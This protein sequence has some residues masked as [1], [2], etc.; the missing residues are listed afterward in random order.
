LDLGAPVSG[1]GLGGSSRDRIAEAVESGVDLLESDVLPTSEDALDAVV[2]ENPP[3][4]TETSAVDLAMSS[5]VESGRSRS[6]EE[7]IDL[8]APPPVS[9]EDREIT[10]G[11][12][13]ESDAIDLG[14]MFGG[15]SASSAS[16]KAPIAEEIED[17]EDALT[18]AA[19]SDADL[20]GD[21]EM[22]EP[23]VREVGKP[24]RGKLGRKG[25]P[26]EEPPA[27]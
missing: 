2:L 11:S 1:V 7:S 3:P 4:M 9:A 23:P 13:L 12:S 15:A 25:A 19:P 22:R 6:D 20:S 5:R 24:A 8:G 18:S 27:T 16:T 21:V 26:E 17:E 10:P 14:A